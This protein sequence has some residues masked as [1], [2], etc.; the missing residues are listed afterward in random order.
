MCTTSFAA[1]RRY[2]LY[3]RHLDGTAAAAT[4]G[5]TVGEDESRKEG[6][7]ERP[8]NNH[9]RQERCNLGGER[10]D[11][12]STHDEYEE[13]FDIFSVEFVDEH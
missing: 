2:P 5:T 3:A 13:L 4:A 9:Q 10:A 1:G 6:V 12:E 7:T 8:L 11:E